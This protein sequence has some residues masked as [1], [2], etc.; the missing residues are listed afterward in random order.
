VF[1]GRIEFSGNLKGYG[2]IVV[3]NHGSRYFTVTAYLERRKGEEGKIVKAG[4]IIGTIGKDD[5]PSGRRVYFEVRRG[6]TNLDPAEWLK[7][8]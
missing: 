6:G 8:H 4:E 5:S 2:E 3:I 1:P 7:V